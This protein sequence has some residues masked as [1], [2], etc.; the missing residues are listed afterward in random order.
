MGHGDLYTTVAQI[1]PVLLLALMWDSAYLDRLRSEHRPARR[2]GSAGFFWT[3]PR[4]RAF[5]L[6]IAILVMATLLLDVLVLAGVV[7]DAAPVRAA[8]VGGLVVAMGALLF[9]IWVDVVRATAT[10]ADSGGDP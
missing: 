3:K 1:V 2:N 7:P 8:V 5:I 9:R 10:R 6:S 4:V